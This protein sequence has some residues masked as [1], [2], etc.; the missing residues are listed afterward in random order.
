MFIG[1]LSCTIE[2]TCLDTVILAILELVVG[3]RREICTSRTSAN[4][5]SYHLYFSISYVKMKILFLSQ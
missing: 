5:L 2:S 1:S 3:I 4:Y